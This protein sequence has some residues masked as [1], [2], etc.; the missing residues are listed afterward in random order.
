MLTVYGSEINGLV[1]SISQFIGYFSLV[2]AGL[3]S[4]AVYSLYKPLA[5]K[6]TKGINAILSA[7]RHFYNQ[8]VYIFVSIV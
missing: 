8:A 1:T 7:S 3:A 6:D 2:E 4:A 5:E